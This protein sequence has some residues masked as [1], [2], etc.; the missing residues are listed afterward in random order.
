MKVTRWKSKE[1]LRKKNERERE[2]REI[3]GEETEVSLKR[4]LLGSTNRGTNLINFLLAQKV[5]ER[6]IHWKE[7][8]KEVIQGVN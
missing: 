6:R 5:E 7:K 2:R 4:G 8:S 3:E 1:R